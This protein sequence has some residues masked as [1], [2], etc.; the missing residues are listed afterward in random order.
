MSNQTETL[1][2]MDKVR[3]MRL[4]SMFGEI[5]P[6]CVFFFAYEHGGLFYAAM[7]TLSATVLSLVAYWLVEK[8]VARFVIFSTVLSGA[9]TITAVL[10]QEDLLIKV[11]PSVFSFVLSFVLLG[12]LMRN[13][14][15]M[16][17]FFG[18]QFNLTPETWRLL[19]LRWGLF[20]LFAALANELA[21]RVLSEQ[22][23]VYFRVF[24]MPPLTGGFMLAMLPLTLRGTIA[25]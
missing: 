10:V 12:G 7:A 5:I 17:V 21:W 15:M 2:L 23:W 25:K 13:K 1:T 6:L 14:A 22:H 4:V 11:Q 16:E 8:R 3:Q 20:F 24:V 18:T 9:M 19:S